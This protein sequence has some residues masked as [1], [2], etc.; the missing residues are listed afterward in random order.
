MVHQKLIFHLRLSRF[1]LKRFTPT[2]HRNTLHYNL[3]DG[4]NTPAPFYWYFLCTC[5]LWMKGNDCK[6][7][8]WTGI[9]VSRFYLSFSFLAHS[10][11][12]IFQITMLAKK[13]SLSTFSL[14]KTF[15]CLLIFWDKTQ[16]LVIQECL[17][18]GEILKQLRVNREEKVKIFAQ[19]IIDLILGRV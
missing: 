15:K 4:A 19:E 18:L 16:L 14:S 17:Y 2:E 10:L 7:T 11:R 6:Y 1:D 8:V 12:F 3:M 13:K 5:E 9:W